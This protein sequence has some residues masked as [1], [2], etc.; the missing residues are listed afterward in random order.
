MIYIK[1]LIV[2]IKE[3]INPKGMKYNVITNYSY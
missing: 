3:L 2:I 1:Y